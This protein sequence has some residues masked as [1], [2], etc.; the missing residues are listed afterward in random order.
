MLL[1][2]HLAVDDTDTLIIN[3]SDE[4]SVDV[5]RDKI[6][7][8][9]LS[10]ANGNFKVVVLDEADFLSTASQAVLRRLMEDSYETVRFILIANLEHKIMPAIKSRCTAQWKFNAPDVASIYHRM[11]AILISENITHTDATLVTFIDVCYPD[12][13]SCISLLQQHS[14]SGTLTPIKD[15]ANVDVVVDG[16]LTKLEQKQWSAARQSLMSI[17]VSDYP[18]LYRTLY[19]QL[20]TIAPFTDAAILEDGIVVIAEYLDMMQRS[21]GMEEIPTVAMFIALCKIK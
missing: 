5:M 19:Q 3:A 18:K 9:S 14:R 17:P 8:F 7:N 1:L 21:P 15:D 10:A 6:T 20:H 4:N 11:K 2:H 16:I 13:R 12:I